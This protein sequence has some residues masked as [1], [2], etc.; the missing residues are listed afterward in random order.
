MFQQEVR[1]IPTSFWEALPKG[2]G[3]H[4]ATNG[5]PKR[6]PKGRAGHTSQKTWEPQAFGILG[7]ASFQLRG[8]TPAPAFANLRPRCAAATSA[9]SAPLAHCAVHLVPLEQTRVPQN[10]AS[11][12]PKLQGFDSFYSGF[13]AEQAC[14]QCGVPVS[15]RFYQP[16]P[17]KQTHLD[18]VGVHGT[19]PY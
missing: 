4:K 3:V 17:I 8:H 2:P 11:V 14:F 1:G 5:W 10:M 15:C 9:L 18:I 12:V 13:R 7:F 6:K 16:R 19:C